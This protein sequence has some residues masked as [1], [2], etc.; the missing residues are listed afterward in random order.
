MKILF[1]TDS[2]ALP[3]DKP[4]KVDFGN[5][6]IELFKKANSD[7]DVQQLSIGGATINELVK[8]AKYYKSFHPDYVVV[9]SGI[10]D[11]APRALHKSEQKLLKR[12]PFLGKKLLG[13]IASQSTALRKFRKISYTKINHF[14]TFMGRLK[15]VFSE[16]KIIAVAIMPASKEYEKIVP[17]ITENIVSYNLVLKQSFQVIGGSASLDMVMSD[18]HHLNEQ[19]HRY[20][21]NELVEALQLNTH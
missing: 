3:R 20:I 12:T 6:Y 19:G 15:E 16:S 8:A 4:E 7:V 5:T 13:W 14:Q 11:C 17:G 18:F 2:L 21:F 9:Q 10:V 1:L